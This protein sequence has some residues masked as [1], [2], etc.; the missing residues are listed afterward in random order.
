MN[1][2]DNLKNACNMLNKKK[3][4]DNLFMRIY[5]FTT[6]NIGGYIDFFD[7]KD[8]SLLTIGS[9]GDQIL[10]SYLK[11]CRD[12]TLLDINPYAKYYIYL[13]IAG[14]VSLNYQEFQEFFFVWLGSKFNYKRYNLE[15]FE[16]LSNN[17]K[18]LNY[19]SYYF[20]DKIFKNYDR[21]KIS[22]Y[23]FIDD[24]DNFKVISKINKYLDNEESYLKLKKIVKD[25]SFK[26]INEDIF[27][28]E[29]STKY[30]NIFLSNICTLVNLYELRDL[31][32][33]LKN[34]NLSIDGSMLF[35]YLWNMRFESEEVNFDWK[36]VY[37]MPGTRD[38]L[39]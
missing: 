2:E 31:L 21:D 13:K 37:Q 22:K 38:M 5:T 14:I 1:I 4:D 10:N 19:D 35:V 23:L 27:K 8:K 34:N 36:Q 15:L 25:I 24:E 7:L 6:E 18:A 17:L 12:I 28:Y 29:S 16:K 9:S 20:F 11:G 3:L 33:K 39:R 26:F 32:I 30:D